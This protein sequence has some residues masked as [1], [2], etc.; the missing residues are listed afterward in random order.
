MRGIEQIPWLYDVS[1]AMLPGIKRWRRA[2]LE[3]ARGR[4]LEVGCGTGLML[5][6]Y[7]EEH[8]PVVGLE[9]DRV[10]LRRAAGRSPDGALCRASVEHL[11]FAD[12]SF[13]TVVSGLVFCSVNDAERGLAEIARVLKTDGRLLMLEHVHARSAAGRWLLDRIQPSWTLITGGCHPNRDT[14]QIVECAG[15]RIERAHY[16]ARGLLR[17]FVA[18][19]AVSPAAG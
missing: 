12:F 13:D 16:R 15:F 14:E 6:L 18:R 1:M 19:K 5:P 8:Q 10:A 2:L 9:L 3:S 11:P 7:P 4:V 17:R